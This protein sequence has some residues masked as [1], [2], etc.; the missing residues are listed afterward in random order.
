MKEKENQNLPLNE[1]PSKA[2]EK[3]FARFPET[4]RLDVSAWDT[5]NVLAYFCT[6]YKDY[7]SAEFTFKF[8]ST[9]P[10]K[11]YEVF[12]M[13]KLAQTLSSDPQILKDYIDWWFKVK[14]PLRKKRIYSLAFLT[15][16]IVI[17]EYKVKHLLAG[18]SSTIDR[19]TYIPSNYAAIIA[20]YA[21]N[22]TNYGE[23]AFI[24]RCID[25]GNGEEKYS[26]MLTELKN[27]GMDIAIL[28][29]VK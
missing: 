29:R 15:D 4:E 14:V 11:S 25:S 24:K 20:K 28:D 19:T 26:Q 2:W 9:A 22:I 6:K 8:N 12:Q 18:K 3:F 1:Y 5:T 17:N 16:Q 7:Y 23:L 21:S 10:S 27:N 13:R